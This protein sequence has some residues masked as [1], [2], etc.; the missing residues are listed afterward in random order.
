[1]KSI[2]FVFLILIYS[3][4]DVQGQTFR[5]LESKVFGRWSV[6]HNYYQQVLGL[7]ERQI[8]TYSRAQVLFS[9]DVTII[10]DDTLYRPLYNVQKVAASNYVSDNYGMTKQDLG[11]T[12]QY[13]YV[14]TI[15]TKSIP[16][17]KRGSKPNFVLT[18][19]IL[20]DG[21]RIYFD[22][23]GVIF[24]MSS[25]RPPLGRNAGH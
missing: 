6:T 7:S 4:L 1:M 10:F 17:S 22:K 25:Y 20:Y 3:A 12:S 9:K 19:E 8:N 5:D 23:D 16:S 11:I 18:D 21:K 24:S 2:N 15:L 14:I 13:L